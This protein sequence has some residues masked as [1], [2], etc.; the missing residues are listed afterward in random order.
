[1]SQLSGNIE[2]I[3]S[4]SSIFQCRK[5]R[6]EKSNSQGHQLVCC[7]TGQAPDFWLTT[8]HPLQPVAPT[9]S[10]GSPASFLEHCQ[11]P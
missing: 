5:M 1:M 4:S 11:Q 8:L 6:L 9:L 10:A 3:S 7:R 2:I